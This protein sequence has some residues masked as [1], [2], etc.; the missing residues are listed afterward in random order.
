MNHYSKLAVVI[1]RVLGALLVLTGIMGVMYCLLAGLLLDKTSPDLAYQSSRVLSA[2]IF[3]AIG[4]L[5]YVAG[6]PIGKLVGKGLD[7]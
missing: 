3:M 7:V 6:K 5:V 4:I 2:G 1:I